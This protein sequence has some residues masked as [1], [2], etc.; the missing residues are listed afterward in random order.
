MD[1]DTGIPVTWTTETN[2]HGVNNRGA[3][4]GPGRLADQSRSCLEFAD[5]EATLW[6]PLLL[7]GRSPK[8]AVREPCIATSWW[9]AGNMGICSMS[10]PVH[11][12]SRSTLR[13]QHDVTALWRA[14]HDLLLW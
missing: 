5:V 14:E 4:V 7:A 8:V 1:C 3:E 9:P 6:V 12:A 10:G 11:A 13:G 2:G